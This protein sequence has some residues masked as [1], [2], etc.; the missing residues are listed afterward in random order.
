MGDIFTNPFLSLPSKYPSNYQLINIEDSMPT[1]SITISVYKKPVFLRRAYPYLFPS[2]RPKTPWH[3]KVKNVCQRRLSRCTKVHDASRSA[4][5]Y[6]TSSA[7]SKSPLSEESLVAAELEPESNPLT[8]PGLS[9]LPNAQLPPSNNSPR[10]VSRSS[11]GSFSDTHQQTSVP[12]SPGTDFKATARNSHERLGME[13]ELPSIPRPPGFNSSEKLLPRIPSPCP[14][15]S[16]PLSRQQT[17]SQLSRPLLS[18]ATAST[19]ELSNPISLTA[20]PPGPSVPPKVGHSG[21]VVVNIGKR[22]KVE[23]TARV[24]H[25]GVFHEG[26]FQEGTSGTV[27]RLALAPESDRS[28]RAFLNEQQHM[29]EA[30]FSRVGVGSAAGSGSVSPVVSPVQVQASSHGNELQLLTASSTKVVGGDTAGTGTLGATAKARLARSF[31][32]LLL[33]GHG[34]HDSCRSP[35]SSTR[36]HASKSPTSMDL[37]LDE[38]TL[39]ATPRAKAHVGRHP[40]AYNSSPRPTSGFHGGSTTWCGL[41]FA[42]TQAQ[43]YGLGLAGL[44]GNL[45][46]LTAVAMAAVL[47]LLSFLSGL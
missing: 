41:D 11:A 2:Y 8:P 39:G 43:C 30:R 28:E 23:L 35:V 18:A 32:Q 6:W 10:L 7:F 13:K 5:K 16:S 36:T 19:T 24:F 22:V 29:D 20:S 26:T 12:C 21:V 14:R 37:V 1:S 38:E 45:K 33:H 15:S 46:T 47:L 44:R 42:V 3:I 25:E 27:C 31:P 4:S 40:H 9:P 34:I 17:N